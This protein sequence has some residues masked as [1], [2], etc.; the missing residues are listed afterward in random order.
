VFHFAGGLCVEQFPV[1]LGDG[2]DGVVGDFKGGLIVD[3]CS[4]WMLG[5]LMPAEVR[6]SFMVIPL[7]R[8]PDRSACLLLNERSGW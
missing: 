5:L 6:R 1:S 7:G 3:G 4:L 8:N 2:F